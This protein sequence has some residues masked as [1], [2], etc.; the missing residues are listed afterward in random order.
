VLA[1]TSSGG[2]LL[3]L[4]ALRPWFGRHDTAWVA[5]PDVDTREALDDER[6]YW[7]PDCERGSSR[8]LVRRFVDASRV[9]AHERPDVVVSAGTGIAVP[10][11]VAAKLRRVPSVWIDTFNVVDRSGRVARLCSRL[12]ALTLVQREQLL[13]LRPRAHLIGELY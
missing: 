8:S 1:V 11:F 7:L 4:L 6:V 2:V 5:V 3:D 13:S 9:L 12:A 10:F